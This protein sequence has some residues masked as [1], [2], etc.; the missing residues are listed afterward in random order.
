M[1]SFKGVAPLTGF[2]PPIGR[3]EPGTSLKL[4]EVEGVRGNRPCYPRVPDAVTC[5]S[6]P[7]NTPP[8]ARSGSFNPGKECRQ[9]L[10]NPRGVSIGPDPGRALFCQ[11]LKL[12]STC[13]WRCAP[14]APPPG[15]HRHR[16][17]AWQ[18]EQLRAGVE[19]PT[20]RLRGRRSGGPLMVYSKRPP[21]GRWSLWAGCARPRRCGKPSFE[22]AAS[23]AGAPGFSTP[24]A[25]STGLFTKRAP[26]PPALPWA[27]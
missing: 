3:P 9:P 10:G 5:P 6:C 2:E 16:G 18:S 27:R 26:N 7:D 21:P 24:P 11:L 14:G 4:R 17:G 19:L 25:G 8:S 1:A 20:S 22:L 13:P 15:R 23:R 12:D